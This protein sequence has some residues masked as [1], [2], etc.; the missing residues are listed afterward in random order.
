MS[1]VVTARVDPET[2]AKLD[3][4]AR[5]YGRSRSWLL[6]QAIKRYVD[7]SCAYLAFVAEGADA[8]DRG[9]VVAHDDVARHFDERFRKRTAA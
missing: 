9:D 3:L 5:T 7:E 4:I 6:A 2:A 1:H 8:A